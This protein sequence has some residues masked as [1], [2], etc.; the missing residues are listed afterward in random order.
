MTYV[1]VVERLLEH[2][3]DPNLRLGAG[4]GTALCS[5]TT[6]QALKWRDGTTSLRMVSGQPA[7]I[8]DCVCV[9]VLSHLIISLSSCAVRLESSCTMEPVSLSQSKWLSKWLAL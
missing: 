9:C 7:F 1:Q 8:N 2:G 3:G 5:L 6:Q 4:V